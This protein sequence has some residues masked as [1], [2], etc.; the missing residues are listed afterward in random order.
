MSGCAIAALAVMKMWKKTS[1]IVLLHIGAGHSAVGSVCVSGYTVSWCRLHKGALYSGW[2][3]CFRVHCQLVQITQ[4]GIVQ[5]VVWVFQGT[6]SAGADYTEGHC[7]VGGVGVSGYT[8]S[9]CRL[10]RRALCSGWC[11]CFRVHCQQVQ[12]TQK[13]IVQWVVRVFQGTLSAGADY[14][15]GH[16][17]VGSVCVSG[18]TVSWYSCLREAWRTKVDR[19]RKR[20][21]SAA[22]RAVDVDGSHCPSLQLMLWKPL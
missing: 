22:T 16:C 18:Y 12:I 9:W 4:R 7:T 8:V 10:H 11:G 3:G 20:V 5:W 13:G 6:L 15:E 2:C 19:R 17:T 21:P 14:T 1:T